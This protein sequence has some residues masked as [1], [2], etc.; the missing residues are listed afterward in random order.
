[1]PVWEAT[2]SLEDSRHFSRLFRAYLQESHLK[3]SRI[4]PSNQS[5]SGFRMLFRS[6]VT[7]NLPGSC[8]FWK[9][10][11]QAEDVPRGF[12]LTGRPW[13]DP[14]FEV[15]STQV[16]IVWAMYVEPD[17]RK[18]G[19]A[20]ELQVEGFKLASEKYRWEFISASVLVG[21]TEALPLLDHIPVGGSVEISYLYPLGG[22]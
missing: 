5:M 4:I 22:S 17:F 20:R 2:T 6:Y 9:P 13:S 1:M 3:G 7:G 14:F 11:D 12:T 16:G 15:S 10:E 8:L 19:G 18:M 21:N